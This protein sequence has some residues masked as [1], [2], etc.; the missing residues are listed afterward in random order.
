MRFALLI[1]G[2]VAIGLS[3]KYGA[4]RTIPEWL[5]ITGCVGGAFIIV[6][7]GMEKKHG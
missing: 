6:K 1:F 3:A 4:I 5:A 7:V 2:I